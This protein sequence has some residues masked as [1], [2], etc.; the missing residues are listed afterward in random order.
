MQH[1]RRRVDAGTL[2]G[3]QEAGGG[4]V[5][6]RGIPYAAPPV[7]PLRWRPPQLPEPWSGERDASAFAPDAPQY[8]L[9]PSS[10]YAGGHERQ[11][12]DCL[13]LN[14]W[15]P[16][17]PEGPL[18]VL[19]WLH[20][21]AFQFGGASA[22]FY[23]GAHLAA[24]G[25]VVVTVNHRLGRLGFLAHPALSAE[26]A[27]ASSGNY[28]LLDQIAALEWVQRNIAA[29]G[30]DPGNVTFGGL[31]AGSSAVNLLLTSPLTTGLF[32]RAIGMSGAQLGP[33]GTSGGLG[34]GLQDLASA[35]GSGRLVFGD[36]SA[37]DLRR[38]SVAEVMRAQLP[39]DSGP[40][41]H[42]DMGMPMARN[43]FDASYPIVD[44][45]V[46]PVAPHAAYTA[47]R[48]HNVPLLTGSAA[49]ERAGVPYLPDAA[50]FEADARAELGD[51]ADEFLALFPPGDTAQTRL[52]SQRANA[53]RIFIWQNWTWARLHAARA[54]AFHYHTTRR[55]PVPAGRYV[56]HDP[57]AF[58]S[59]EL[60]YMF[61][62]LEVRDWPW[63]DAD[64]RLS[65][66]LSAQV[67][68]F[69]RTGNPNGP[70]LPDWP[71]FAE[72]GRATMLLGDEIAAGAMPRGAQLALWDRF[73]GAR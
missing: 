57:G 59:A 36:V 19:V 33:V 34:D 44:G 73:F 3:T 63:E 24:T 6:F 43:I 38:L 46:V 8:E 39:P 70:G 21:G 62:N 13:Y 32:Q 52:S 51:L 9:V 12:E 23:D 42:V 67:R 47:G 18:P 31:S 72:P 10:L 7:G 48:F 14:V 71:A 69:C 16:A 61:R 5:A 60:P 35:E 40:S 4:V 1:A 56:E 22:P 54:P 11:S 29:F 41:W 64:R 50:L 2:D 58:H 28:G 27:G 20:F 68:Q 55:P 45:H 65:A 37:E 66:V 26:S 25:L 49:D 17:N 30:G 53:D 15:A